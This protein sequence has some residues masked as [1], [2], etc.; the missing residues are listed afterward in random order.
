MHNNFKT[1]NDFYITSDTWFGRPQILQIANRKFN[2]VDE[3]NAAL[4]KNWNKAI[5]KD[6]IVFHLGNFAWDPQTARNVLKKLKGQ[7]YFMIGSADE[8]FLDIAHEFE[9]V[10][11]IEDQIL[12]LPQFDSII[13]HYP[14]AVWNGKDSGTIHFHGHTIFSHKTDLNAQRRVNVCT[15][16]WNFAPVNYLTIKD[17]IN[18]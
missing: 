1:L 4:I 15:D 16:Y 2:D 6:D 5:K 11:I 9:N 17:F 13:C 12:E 7:I 3:M 10:T 18:E 14:L 8:A